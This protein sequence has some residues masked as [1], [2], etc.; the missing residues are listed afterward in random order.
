MTWLWVA[1]DNPVGA[2]DAETQYWGFGGAELWNHGFW[3]LLNFAAAN[4]MK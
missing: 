1:R 4:L 2:E 3:N